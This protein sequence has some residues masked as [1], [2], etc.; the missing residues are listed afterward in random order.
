MIW[1][2]FLEDGDVVKLPSLEWTGEL[3]F[4]WVGVVLFEFELF[5]NEIPVDDAE[6]LVRECVGDKKSCCKMFYEQREKKQKK[7][8][9]K[10][11][12]S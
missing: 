11:K 7:S 5:V 12:I 4:D 3:L 2:P 10:T 1:Q 9:N 6:L 8:T